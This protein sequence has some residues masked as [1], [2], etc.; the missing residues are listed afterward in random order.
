MDVWRATVTSWEVAAFLLSEEE[1][2]SRGQKT[3]ANKQPT[4]AAPLCH[5][6]DVSRDDRDD[7][8][9]QHWRTHTRNGLSLDRHVGLALRGPSPVACVWISRDGRAVWSPF[10]S[11]PPKAY[12][13]TVAPS[14]FCLEDVEAWS[15]EVF[16]VAGWPAE[17]WASRCCRLRLRRSPD[18][19]RNV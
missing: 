16:Q 7:T 14:A 12:R 6:K 17:M 1:E 8:S 2:I 19:W 9:R 10:A 15:Y 3:S 13:D 11:D 4:S 18:V 5:E